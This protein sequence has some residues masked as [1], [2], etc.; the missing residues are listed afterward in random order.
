[1]EPLQHVDQLVNETRGARFFTV[2][3]HCSLRPTILACSGCNISAT[4]VTIRRVS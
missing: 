4:S 3:K 2:T 1:M